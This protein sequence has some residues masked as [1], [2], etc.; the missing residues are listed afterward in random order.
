MPE[1]IARHIATSRTGRNCG[2]CGDCVLCLAPL[3]EGK[4]CADCGHIARC[5]AIGFTDS[6]E[7]TYR[8][9]IP[10]RS[11]LGVAPGEIARTAA[12]RGGR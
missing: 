3:P 4:T 6:A 10:S 5:T 11:T 12:W 9:F 8:S 2:G 1:Q 7:N